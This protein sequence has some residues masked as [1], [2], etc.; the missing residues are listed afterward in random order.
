MNERASAIRARSSGETATL[1]LIAASERQPWPV[2]GYP[3]LQKRRKPAFSFWCLLAIGLILAG[4]AGAA[5]WISND[6]PETVSEEQ[7]DELEQRARA[8]DWELKWEFAEAYFYGDRPNGCASLQHG[9]RCR[10][11]AS[12]KAAGAAFFQE[13]IDSTPKNKTD[14][15]MIGSLQL[16]YARMRYE[17]SIPTYDPESAACRDAVRYAVK[18]LENGKTCAPTFLG[19][20]ASLGRCLPKDKEVATGYYKQDSGCP[21]D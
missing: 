8:G 9:Y 2:L 10:A 5:S 16:N 4:E 11:M 15:M 7:L 18:A 14:R 20:M 6:P 3:I 13:L 19:R 21:R 1:P 17:D 12:R